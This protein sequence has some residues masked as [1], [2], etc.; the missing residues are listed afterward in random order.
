M[1]NLSA[2]DVAEQINSTDSFESK[3][4]VVKQLRDR[5][6]KPL[7]SKSAKGYTPLHFEIENKDIEGVRAILESGISPN[8]AV[9][10]NHNK[11]Y[12]PLHLALK[13]D[14]S[15]EIVDML[16]NYG[17]K[18][19]TLDRHG[20]TPVHYAVTHNKSIDVIKYLLKA[21]ADVNLPDNCGN[22]ILHTLAKTKAEDP[23]REAQIAEGLLQAGAHIKPHR[24]FIETPIHFAV[25]NGKTG[26]LSSIINSK[27]GRTQ[28]NA[29]DARGLT[30]LDYAE[31]FENTKASKML[32]KLNALHG[33]SNEFNLSASYKTPEERFSA[34]EKASIEYNKTHCFKAPY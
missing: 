6:G 12:T 31:I 22:S 14:C 34:I 32:K 28:I 18:L 7:Y 25:R 11:I 16:V 27:A 20:L 29:M 19:D 9:V 3:F 5:Q 26:V 1:E 10:R 8:V 21:G 2:I 13:F 15:I 30:A 17:A 24:D 23:E 4:S 33:M